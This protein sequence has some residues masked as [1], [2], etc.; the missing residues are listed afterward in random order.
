MAVSVEKKARVSL[1]ASSNPSGGDFFFFTAASSGVCV[2]GM[3][4][5]SKGVRAV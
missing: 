4:R 1:I 5:C 2:V 3:S